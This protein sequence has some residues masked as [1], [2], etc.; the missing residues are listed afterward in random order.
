MTT[1]NIPSMLTPV[2]EICGDKIEI[3]LKVK[4]IH[5]WIIP[6]R[7]NPTENESLHTLLLDEKCGKI[8]ATI[9][10]NLIPHFKEIF[11]E[12]STYV[13]EKILVALND[14]SFTTTNHK[15]KLNFMG[16]TNLFKV[17]APEIHIHHFEFMSFLNILS[18]TKEDKLLDIIGHVDKKNSIKEI[19]K[20]G[21]KVM[22]IHLKIWSTM[23]VCNSFFETK[24][25]LN[26]DIPAINDYKLRLTGE[27][28]NL[29][30]GVSQMTGSTIIPL[31]DDLLQT[32]KNTIE[33][34]IEST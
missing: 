5:L 29:T 13:F 25:L 2:S 27:N 6:D 1:N 34:L 24:M 32:K 31:A 14:V 22:D 21:K 9:Q 23:G 18:S 8:H 3:N 10:K 11:L 20:N 7:I 33:D 19:E 26:V 17:N 30:Q 28:A 16:S 15:D 12:G 4:V